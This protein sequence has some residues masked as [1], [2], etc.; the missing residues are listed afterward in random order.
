MLDNVSLFLNAE[1]LLNVRQTKYDPLLPRRAATSA[2]TVDAW[3]PIDGFVLNGGVRFRFGGGW[4]RPSVRR[5]AG[6]D[7]PP[8]RQRQHGHDHRDHDVRLQRL[9]P[10]QGTHHAEVRQYF[11]GR[12]TDQERVQLL[13]FAVP[14]I[15]RADDRGPQVSAGI[16]HVGRRA[17][18]ALNQG[19]LPSYETFAL[20]VDQIESAR[21]GT[22]RHGPAQHLHPYS[23]KGQPERRDRHR[24][25]TH[26]EEADGNVIRTVR[27]G[28]CS[29]I[30]QAALCRVAIAATSARPRPEP[31][32][33][34][35]AS[36]R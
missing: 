21:T 36:R 26:H 15:S 1:N 31:S 25:P 7:L 35:L 19:F 23:V 17:V 32:V 27:P 13:R 14:R 28:G 4:M 12:R 11:G 5:E 30:I 2:W 22:S 6:D 33:W 18:T 16:F 24:R 20:G 3:A 9:K 34:R 10:D 29:G 8:A